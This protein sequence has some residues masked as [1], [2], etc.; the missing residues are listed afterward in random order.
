M[1]EFLKHS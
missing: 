1:S